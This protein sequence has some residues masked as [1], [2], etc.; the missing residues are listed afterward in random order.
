MSDYS[1]SKNEIQESLEHAATVEHDDGAE[2]EAQETAGSK[3]DGG[4]P[5]RRRSA[6]AAKRKEEDD[7]AKTGKFYNIVATVPDVATKLVKFYGAC[8][9]AAA[10]KVGNEVFRQTGTTSFRVIMR[11]AHPSKFKRALY[12]YRVEIRPVQQ[13]SARFRAKIDGAFDTSD[14]KTLKDPVKLIKIVESSD[15]PVYGHV[16]ENGTIAPG[17]G[18]GKFVV[19]R[20]PSK[21]TLVM[22]AA[23]PPREVRGIKVSITDSEPIAT[24]EE[25]TEDEIAEHDVTGGVRARAIPKKKKAAA[26]ATAADA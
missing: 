6:T 5:K 20:D 25:L 9:S 16:S 13:V 1:L 19:R 22:V 15:L 14:G 2:R 23:K 7:D 26:A 21:N 17:P 3:L 8:P 4:A 24:R 12:K 18:D 10:R 11:L